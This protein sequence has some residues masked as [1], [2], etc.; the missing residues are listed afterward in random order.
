MMLRERSRHASFHNRRTVTMI[1]K[2]LIDMIGFISI[3][4][5]LVSLLAIVEGIGMTLGAVAP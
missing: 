4:L 5:L 1:R 2:F 3:I